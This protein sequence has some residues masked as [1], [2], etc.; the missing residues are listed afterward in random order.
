MKL[1]GRWRIVEM[2]LWDQDAIDLVG[3]AFI[4]F[5]PR[6]MGSFRFIVVEGEIDYRR[7]LRDG[8]QG[9][10]FSWEGTDDGDHV[11]G[12]GWVMEDNELLVGHIYFHLGDD[13]GF[14]AERP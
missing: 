6:G 1:D 10:E 4:D 9:F 2:D 14:R 7:T 3:P 12:R 13:S 8:R 5:G 11:S